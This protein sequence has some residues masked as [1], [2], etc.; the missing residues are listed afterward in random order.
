[1]S[2]PKPVGHNRGLADGDVGEGTGVHEAGLAFQRLQEVR[3]DRLAQPGRHRAGHLEVLGR[4]RVALLVVGDHDPAHAFPEVLQVAENRQDGHN[5]GR[6]GDAE[7]ALHLVAVHLAADADDDVA[8][9]LGAEVDDPAHLHVGRIDVEALQPDLGQARVVVVPL[10]LHPGRER[11]HRQVVRVHDGVDVACQPQG[12]LSQRNAL[13]KTAARGRTLDVHCGPAG[14][15]ADA[16]HDLLVAFAHALQK[17]HRGGRFALAH[18]R[19]RNR[20]DLNELAVR[21]VFEPVEHAHVIHLGDEVA[22][23]KQLL[24]ADAQFLGKLVARLHPGFG[25]FR[26]LPIGVFCRV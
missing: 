9:G 26:D 5:L 10:V 15:L 20:G 16:G 4:D 24:L 13:G 8:K 23:G 3:V 22:V 11:H 6:N 2:A 19:R 25:F 14:R 1:M 7:L 18:G 21:L 17:S 12:K